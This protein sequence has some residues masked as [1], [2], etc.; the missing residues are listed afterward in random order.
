MKEKETLHRAEDL[1]AGHNTWLLCCCAVVPGQED[2]EMTIF[3]FFFSTSL[4]PGPALRADG[5]RPIGA[6]PG[7]GFHTRQELARTGFAFGKD[8]SL[9][10][11]L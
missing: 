3:N 1:T 10:V 8:L 9:A 5:A 7:P 11:G 4:R 6:A 2:A